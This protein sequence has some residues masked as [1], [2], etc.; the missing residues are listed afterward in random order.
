MVFSGIK[1]VDLCSKELKAHSFADVFAKDIAYYAN[2]DSINNVNRAIVNPLPWIVF[3]NFLLW[4]GGPKA[5]RIVTTFT[6]RFFLFF[7]S[8]AGRSPRNRLRK[9]I[10]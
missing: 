1:G 6:F 5:H 10:E 8:G 7:I 9:T 2:K 4:G 3:L